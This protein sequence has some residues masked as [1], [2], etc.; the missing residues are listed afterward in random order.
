M[1]LFSVSWVRIRKSSD[2]PLGAGFRLI[3]EG[4]P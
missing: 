4:F 2:S 1:Q 3:T